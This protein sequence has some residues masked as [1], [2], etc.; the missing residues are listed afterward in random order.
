MNKTHTYKTTLICIF[1]VICI[2]YVLWNRLGYER[3]KLLC[4]NA[5]SI[6]QVH[7]PRDIASDVWGR[8]GRF[9]VDIHN[10]RQQISID[11]ALVV[12]NRRGDTI[13]SAHINSFPLSNSAARAEIKRFVDHNSNKNNSTISQILSKYDQWLRS[14]N[15]NRTSDVPFLVGRIGNNPSMDISVALSFENTRPWCVQYDIVWR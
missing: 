9:V 15:A 5:P 3:V 14:V 8:S 11:A 10:A 7:W 2:A 1:L 6:E 12:L 13:S 4:D